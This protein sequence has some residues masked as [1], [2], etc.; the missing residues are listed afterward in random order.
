[1][2]PD[3]WQLAPGK[4]YLWWHSAW[5]RIVMYC[6]S[7]IPWVCVGHKLIVQ[8]VDCT[9]GCLFLNNLPLSQ[10]IWLFYPLNSSEYF[11]Y[12][13]LINNICSRDAG[14]SMGMCLRKG[15]WVCIVSYFYHHFYHRD[16]SCD[17]PTSCGSLSWSF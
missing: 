7:H 8:E 1:M 17:F 3:P 11:C 13:Q 15:I 4:N 16:D 14:R 10:T 9:L 5:I 6:W 2:V 12:C